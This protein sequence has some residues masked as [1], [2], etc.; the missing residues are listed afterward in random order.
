MEFEDTLGHDTIGLLGEAN[1]HRV[2]TLDCRSEE[3]YLSWEW[4]MYF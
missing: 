3:D 4:E 1:R 2:P